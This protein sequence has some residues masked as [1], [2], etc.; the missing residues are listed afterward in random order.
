MTVYADQRAHDVT[1][2]TAAERG[3]LDTARF[4]VKATRH[5]WTWTY[6]NITAGEAQEI[7][8]KL[9]AHDG[10]PWIVEPVK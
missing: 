9:T 7:A 8:D 1:W 4:A 10:E 3:A 5:D 6:S 2:M